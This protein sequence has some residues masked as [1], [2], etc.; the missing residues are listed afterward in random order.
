MTFPDISEVRSFE[1][2]VTPTAAHRPH[3]LLCPSAGGRSGGPLWA[4]MNDAVWTPVRQVRVQSL[5]P[6]PSGTHVRAELLGPMVSLCLAS[7]GATSPFSIVATLQASSQQGFQFL[8]IL[9][10][11]CYSL[12]GAC[13]SR[14]HGRVTCSTAVSCA[15]PSRLV[16][17]GYLLWRN[18]YSPPCPI[19][20]LACLL[21][22][23]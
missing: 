7:W 11:T 22:E 1:D 17:F 13:V 21:V 16:T 9:D 19:Y 3:P 14:L 23:L 5:L 15:S 6:M 10:H 18:V 4:P 20:D 12:R 8:H 2:S